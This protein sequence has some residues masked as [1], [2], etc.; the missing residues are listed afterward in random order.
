MEQKRKG[1]GFSIIRQPVS[2]A[3]TSQRIFPAN[4]A[5]KAEIHVQ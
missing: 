5:H 1:Y 2:C 3:L 4:S